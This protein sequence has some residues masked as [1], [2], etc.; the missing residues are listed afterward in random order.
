MLRRSPSAVSTPTTSL[1]MIFNHTMAMMNA[2]DTRTAS[3]PQCGGLLGLS[4]TAINT[5]ITIP[6]CMEGEG[7]GG[8]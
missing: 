4:N 1:A 8:G 2:R 5:E 3:I 6:A 7:G